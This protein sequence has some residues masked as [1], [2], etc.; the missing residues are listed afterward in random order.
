MKELFVY[1]LQCRDGTYYTGITNDVLKRIDEHQSGLDPECYTYQRRPIALV[2]QSSAFKEWNDAIAFEK[3]LK[4]WS[5]KKKAALIRGEWEALPELSKNGMI[6][7][8]KGIR[9]RARCHASTVLSMTHHK[10]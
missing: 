1:M 5:R 6:R 7:Q 9:S 4:G 8:I 10:L 2:Y 3:Q